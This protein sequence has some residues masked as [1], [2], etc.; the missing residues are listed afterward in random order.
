MLAIVLERKVD[1]ASLRLVASSS[2]VGPTAEGWASEK[3][4]DSFSLAVVGP[5]VTLFL[6][7]AI[8]WLAVELTIANP[9]V[10]FGSVVSRLGAAGPEVPRLKGDGK[11]E[12]LRLDFLAVFPEAL[13]AWAES[14][15]GSFP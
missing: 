10:T 14:C 5:N 3:R 12:V 2:S 6:S 4:L 9:L 11:E 13:K 7:R 1:A 8:P 15:C